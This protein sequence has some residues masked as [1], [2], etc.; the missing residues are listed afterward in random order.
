MIRSLPGLVGMRLDQQRLEQALIR[1][2]LQLELFVLLRPKTRLPLVRDNVVEID[3][4]AIGPQ[5]RRP[6]PA[7]LQTEADDLAALGTAMLSSGHGGH[8]CR[9]RRVAD[10]AADLV[11]EVAIRL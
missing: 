4:G 3:L 7:L 1:F 10:D 5:D 2:D 6:E 11:A 9:R 8:S